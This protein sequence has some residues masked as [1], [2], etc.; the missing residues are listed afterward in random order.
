M[1]FEKNKWA[2]VIECQYSGVR[3]F[4]ESFILHL[5]LPY[6]KIGLGYNIASIFRKR[7]VKVAQLLTYQASAKN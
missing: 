5:K 1:F 7:N 6:A 4:L 3:V 2:T